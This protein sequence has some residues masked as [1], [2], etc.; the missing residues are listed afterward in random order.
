MVEGG[1][2]VRVAEDEVVVGED[3]GVGVFGLKEELFGDTEG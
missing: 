3:M 2:V 1:V